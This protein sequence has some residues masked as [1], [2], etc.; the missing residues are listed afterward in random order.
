MQEIH[1]SCA[2]AMELNFSCTNPSICNTH[3]HYI[4]S[5]IIIF[6]L[7]FDLL[8]SPVVGAATWTK[9][10]LPSCAILWADL[11]VFIV[12]LDC[13]LCVTRPCKW[14][15]CSWLSFS[16]P[17]MSVTQKSTQAMT[18]RV[19]NVFVLLLDI[20]LSTGHIQLHS[21]F[22]LTRRVIC[23]IDWLFEIFA[24]ALHADDLSQC[25]RWSLSIPHSIVSKQA[26]TVHGTTTSPATPVLLFLS[27]L[28]EPE[29][30]QKI[31]L[32]LLAFSIL[33]AELIVWNHIFFHQ[34]VIMPPIPL[35]S[36]H[37]NLLNV[38]GFSNNLSLPQSQAITK[39]KFEKLS[40]KR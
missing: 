5:W 9:T 18:S 29:K 6:L 37:W 40:L 3:Y 1:S 14:V 27:H 35:A 21:Y 22:D 33:C 11:G 13:I 32:K 26:D 7:L 24:I 31:A 15:S 34:L 10:Y 30:Q 39:T 12:L 19:L 16:L 2:L 25:K 23:G 17:A 8:S 4:N 38:K 20:I 28:G 36:T